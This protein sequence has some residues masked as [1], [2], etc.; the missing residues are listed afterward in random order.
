LTNTLSKKRTR[1]TTAK[2]LADELVTSVQQ[3][4]RI[5]KRPEMKD[6]IVKLGEKSVRVNKEMFYQILEQ[7][8]R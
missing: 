8:Y 3:I 7:I 5:L 2:E 6:A 4:Y 1:Y